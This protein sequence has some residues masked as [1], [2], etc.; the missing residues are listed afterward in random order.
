MT[1]GRDTSVQ[2][3][4]V[5]SSFLETIKSLDGQI[6]HISYHQQRFEAVLNSS[7]VKSYSH[8]LDYLHP[9]KKGLY[10]CRILYTKESIEVTYHSYIKRNIN[11]LKLV[12][13]DKIEY[14]KKYADRSD[15]DRLMLLKEGC[16]DILIVKNSLIT[17]TSIANIALY[18]NGVWYTPKQALLN[19]VTRER[20]LKEKK[21]VP[22]DIYVDEI[23]NYEKVALLNA[24]I[25][26]DIIAHEN[27]GEIIC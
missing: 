1:R 24:M 20:L 25:D 12:V 18:K 2:H 22:K 15:I 13:D 21:I 27:I 9:P 8:L 7:G 6:F 14:A 5:K 17:D 16:D 11:S 3:F 26:F 4:L 23:Y 19:G 10:R